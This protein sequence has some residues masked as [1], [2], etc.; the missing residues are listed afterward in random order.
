MTDGRGSLRGL[1][2]LHEVVGRHQAVSDFG[3]AREVTN[4]EACPVLPAIH[5]HRV[6]PD[7]GGKLLTAD[8]LEL[9][10]L[11]E[12]HARLIPLWYN[13]G[14]SYFTKLAVFRVAK[15]K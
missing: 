5:R 2:G 15:R 12:V 10:I 7:S 9:E 1:I 4:W 13:D 6:N 14:K 8:F 11:G 3:N